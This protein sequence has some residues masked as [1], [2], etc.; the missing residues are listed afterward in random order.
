MEANINYDIGEAISRA[1]ID[2]DSHQLLISE[3]KD[4]SFNL[5]YYTAEKI[6]PPANPDPFGFCQ[7]LI[8]F[9]IVNLGI[10]KY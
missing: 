6:D 5:V 7:R 10:W 4:N 8:G 1:R 3:L 2:G 9:K